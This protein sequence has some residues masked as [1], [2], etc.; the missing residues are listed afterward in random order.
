MICTKSLFTGLT[1][2]FVIRV[3]GGF[4]GRR[5]MGQLFGSD[6]AYSGRGYR[7]YRDSII[8]QRGTGVEISYS[9]LQKCE[10]HS[11]YELSTTWDLIHTCS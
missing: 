10:R 5:P 3:V 6:S 7:S 9:A 2:G 1:A 8:L 4:P 11:V